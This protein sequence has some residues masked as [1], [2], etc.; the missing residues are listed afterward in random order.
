MDLKIVPG[1][2]GA[3]GKHSLYG[4]PLCDLNFIFLYEIYE[5]MKQ[6]QHKSSIETNF[7]YKL[8]ATEV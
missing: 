7:H 3:A 6:K 5:V 2:L 4:A 1:T 8:A